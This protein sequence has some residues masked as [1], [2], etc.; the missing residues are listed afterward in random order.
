MAC[1]F[2]LASAPPAPGSTRTVTILQVLRRSSLLLAGVLA[3]ASRAV[4]Q[5]VVLRLSDMADGT[6]LLVTTR[7]AGF[8]QDARFVPLVDSLS[9]EYGYGGGVKRRDGSVWLNVRRRLWR[10][11][12]GRVEDATP[13]AIRARLDPRAWSDSTRDRRVVRIGTERGLYD[14][15][16]HRILA[17]DDSRLWM[18][19]NRGIFWVPRAELTAFAEGRVREVHFTAYTERDGLRNREGNGR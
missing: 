4:V 3:L 13:R 2:L 11:A 8:V 19:T 18:N 5:A 9:I 16:I 7:G 17:D 1:I 6:L 15:A 14:G 12:N 10:I